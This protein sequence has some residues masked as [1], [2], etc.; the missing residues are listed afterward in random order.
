MLIL[1]NRGRKEEG[2]AIDGSRTTGL[3]V[4][5]QLFL[6]LQSFISHGSSLCHC[7]FVYL[8]NGNSEELRIHYLYANNRA[9]LVS[10]FS[11]TSPIVV[12]DPTIESHQTYAKYLF[13]RD[14][15]SLDS[16]NLLVTNTIHPPP[17]IPRK[18]EA[19]KPDTSDYLEEHKPL[20]IP[21]LEKEQDNFQEDKRLPRK[22]GPD[23]LTTPPP[24]L[25]SNN[26][27]SKR[28]LK[29]NAYVHHPRPHLRDSE[30]YRE[31]NPEINPLVLS[32]EN[33]RYYD[34]YL[35]LNPPENR[36]A[37]NYDN[38]QVPE[39]ISAYGYEISPVANPELQRVNPLRRNHINS[40]NT[41]IP[42]RNSGEETRLA[43]YE[44]RSKKKKSKKSSRLNKPEVRSEYE[45]NDQRGQVVPVQPIYYDKA[46]TDFYDNVQ[47][48]ERNPHERH[49]GEDVALEPTE[50]EE[51]R[52]AV[53]RQDN[54][55]GGNQH[56]EVAAGSQREEKHQPK[57]HSEKHEEGGGEEGHED[58]HEADGEE[59]K[60]GYDSHHEHEKGEKGHHDKE[61]HDKHYDEEE[62]KEHK[63]ADDSSYYKHYDSGE[64]KEKESAFDEEGKFNKGHSTKGNHVVHKKDEY[65]K[66]EEFY[67][68][69]HDEDEHEK[70]EGYHH[71][72]EKEH[73]GS[74]KTGHYDAGE[75][76]EE[77]GKKSKYEKGHHYK[78]KKGH[79]QRAGDDKHHEK[80]S[81]YGKKGGYEDGKKWEYKKGH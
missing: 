12:F 74:E 10:A 75:D 22:L 60:K 61:D 11:S 48:A 45:P 79:D 53:R 30:N 36:V 57:V 46:S 32:P 49:Q 65:E 52:P 71:K 8:H 55:G 25:N 19:L 15:H 68:E 26:F 9:P 67:D 20:I 73:G 66:L 18:V 7:V 78:D 56:V 69:S 34:N 29:E 50:K 63:H 40:G 27:V 35:R 54:G 41:N 76:V 64:K 28:H 77:H 81:K 23:K 43:N 2:S 14:Q 24:A 38:V 31:L 47:F 4:M 42:D 1:S 21:A 59:A 80:E 51:P 33:Q 13:S 5:R 17:Q 58:H 6:A 62:G 70:D 16:K 3:V 44:V 72:F 39:P 37:K